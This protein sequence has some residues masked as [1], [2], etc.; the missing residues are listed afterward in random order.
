[1]TESIYSMPNML[2][3]PTSTTSKPIST[4]CSIK[5]QT[6]SYTYSNYIPIGYGTFGTVYKAKCDQTGEFVAIKRVFQDI[7]YKNR[8]LQILLELNHIN[9]VKIK[10]YFY[11]L[12]NKNAN[13][14]YLN[15]VMDFYPESLSQI[16]RSHS[17][18]KT[19][20]SYQEVK[21][22][23][24]QMFHGLNY[25]LCI[26]VCHRD[27]KPQNI[28]INQDTKLLQFCD[29]GSAKK[30]KKNETNVSYICSRYYRAP[31]LIFNAEKYTNAIDVWSVGCV[32]AE[33]ILGTPLFQGES[34]VDQIVEIIKLLGTP[35]KKQIY[36][37]NPEYR[38]YK[39]PVIRCFTLRE[40]FQ[41]YDELGDDFFDL[42]QSIF[43][44]EPSKRITP[45]EA[46]IH[47]FFDSLREKGQFDDNIYQILFDFSQEEIENE[48]NGYI[49]NKLIPSWYSKNIKKE[50]LILPESNI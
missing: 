3:L 19:R 9:V 8:E 33:M 29:F 4:A 38:Q 24:Y 34:S 20:M 30:L 28:L 6:V 1:M 44:Y 43:V 46:M 14:K 18:M 2:K 31:E 27:I 5:N 32:I 21:L 25:L 16:I 42:M 23:A 22:Y 41:K 36:E 49:N 37:M 47:P 26:G 15:V 35:T 45:I 40:V 48:H 10:N 7:R 11:T 50:E 13:E 17:S 39:F 12:N